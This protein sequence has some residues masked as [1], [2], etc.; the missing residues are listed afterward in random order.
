MLFRKKII[1]AVTGSIAAYK[2]AL[3]TRLLV[4]AGA[5][6]RIVM[7]DSAKDFITPLTLSTLSKN[8][9]HSSFTLG[10]QG[11]W[12]N[13]VELGLWADVMVM[14]PASANM[15]ASC[16]NGQCHNL[17]AAV[18]LSARCPVF[19]SPAM[20]LDMWRHPSTQKNIA[21]LR[22][23]GNFIVE[24][25][26]GELASGLVG[27]GRMAEPEAIVKHLE[28]FF[29]L[30]RQMHDKH[31][32]ITAGPTREMIDPVRYISNHSSGKMGYALAE[33]LANRGA[34]ITLVSGPVSISA[35][36]PNIQVMK[37]QTAEEMLHAA[38][39]VFQNV[40]AAIMTAAVADF[41]PMNPAS[42]KIKKTNTTS[43]ILLESTTDILQTLAAKKESHQVVAGF[44]LETNDGRTNAELKVKNKN[45]DFIVLNELSQ[46][47]Q[48]F[49]N[50]FNTIE[51]FG[52]QS[53]W[54]SFEKQTKA[55]AAKEIANYL[56]Q[57]F[58]H[59]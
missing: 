5:E 48:V 32:L 27:E 22:S 17:M 37:V 36:H 15:I 14:A 21:M 3:L 59:A 53:G 44:A 39:S 13:H 20:D 29:N 47:N 41:K 12:V 4:K 49:G 1:L 24:P 2:S 58:N 19:F 16:A 56:D 54:L 23:Y 43:E 52:K 9:V 11:E 8:P 50:D 18:Y 38:E 33:E 35:K 28:A 51:I 6:V 40:N 10:P 7:S 57:L 31:I 45:L 34:R 26:S 55:E 30:S 25:A 46:E 42:E